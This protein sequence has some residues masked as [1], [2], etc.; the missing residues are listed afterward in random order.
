MWNVKN[1]RF[2]KQFISNSLEGNG[3][4]LQ[5]MWEDT[6]TC[7]Q[8]ALRDDFQLNAPMLL[9]ILESFIHV[10]NS[11]EWRNNFTL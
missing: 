9:L 1:L 11:T 4:P 3:E 6:N 8:K 10:R 5:V 7:G 2:A